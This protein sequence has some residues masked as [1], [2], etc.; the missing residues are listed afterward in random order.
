MRL[1]PLAVLAVPLAV[2][3]IG[4]DAVLDGWGLPL[5][6]AALVLAVLG[7]ARAGR[8]AVI[9]AAAAIATAGAGR[10][11]VRWEARH[12]P[13]RAERRIASRLAELQSRQSELV[14]RVRGLGRR[15]AALPDGR[16]A[17]S[18]DRAALIRLFRQLEELRDGV[19]DRPAVAVHS[20]PSLAVVAWSGRIGDP[21]VPAE[22]LT[23]GDDVFVLEGSV[24]TTLVSITSIKGPDGVLRGLV[25]TALPVSARRNIGNEYL[26]DFDLL[27]GGDPRVEA[28]Y[29][30]VREGPDAADLPPLDPALRAREA[31]LRGPDGDPLVLVRVVAPGAPEIREVL[32]TRYRRVLAAL[33]ALALLL[34]AAGAPRQPWQVALAVVGARAFFAFLGPPLP[35]PGSPL[36]SS[37]VYASPLLGLFS[38]SPLDLLMTAASALAVAL[39]ALTAARRRP[40]VLRPLALA[41]AMAAAVLTLVAAG[42]LVLDTVACSLLD[43]EVVTLVPPSQAHAVLQLALLAW[44]LAGLV[45]VTAAF[46]AAGVW[47]RALAALDARPAGARAGAF[48]ALVALAGGLLHPTLV[49]LGQRR[50]QRRLVAE[51]APLVLR[52]PEFR[53]FVLDETRKRI[54]SLRI[55]GEMPTGRARPGIEEMA[56]AVWTATDLAARGFSSAIEIQDAN[57]AVISRFALN[58]PSLSSRPLP[59]N[60]RW[61]VTPERSSLAST[62]RTVR[63]ARRLLTEEGQ[64]RG[65]V[66]VYVADDFWNLP[67]LR[68]SDPYSLLFR[69]APR[70]PVRQDPLVLIAYGRG[71]D[72]TFS[73]VERTPPLPTALAANLQPEGPGEWTV[74]SVDGQEHQ[75][76]L[77]AGQDAVY[78]LAHPRVSWGRRAADLVEAV[79]AFTLV[80]LCGLVVAIVV[81]TVLRKRELSLTSMAAAVQKRFALRLFVAFTVLAVA[82]VVVLEVVVRKFVADRLWEEANKHA[83][84]RVSVARKAVEDFVFFQRGEPAGAE[85]VTDAA[86]VWVASLIRNDLAVF[87]RGRLAASS[88]RELYASGLLA[89]RLSGAVYRTLVLEG[90]PSTLRTERIGGFSYLVASMP[91]RTAENSQS[92]VSLPLASRQREVEATVQD[93]DRTIRLA[94]LVFLGLAALFAQQVARRIS[95]PIRALTSATRRIAEGD[96]ATRVTTSSRDELM[97][98]VESFNQMAGDLDRQRSDL[99][100]S[101]R[102]AAWA[103]MARQVAH[104]VK[105]PLTPI[106]LSAEHLRR[107]WRD[108][109]IDFEGALESCTSTI[110]KQVRILRGIVTEFSAFARPPAAVLE[111]QDPARL[112]EGV[113]EPYRTALPPGVTLSVLSDG[114]VPTVMGD[115]RLLERALVNLLENALQA[116]GEAG[117]IEMGLRAAETG[118]RVELWVEDSG[119]GI[120]PELADRI[121]EPFFST[122]TGGSGLGLPLVRKIAEDHGGGVSLSRPHHGGTRATLW[123][124]TLSQG[125][126][127]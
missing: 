3:L 108:R 66:H 125:H 34:W 109:R 15:V 79:A 10:V 115:R 12:A 24:S 99:E 84:E 47:P 107:V 71:G 67:F 105:N 31:V 33:A 85:P 9:A 20:V 122:K 52:Q 77:F 56:F 49:L 98:L 16:T 5:M 7:G 76:Y 40:A 74:L 23:G 126:A 25:T 119:P 14:E 45:A 101:N 116:V 92:V 87:E 44:V 120:D 123:L 91:V 111:P 55:L 121:F 65:A 2:G 32:E 35:A 17:L 80:A 26:H 41:G 127:A 93:L 90:N 42:G 112:V 124:P 68:T 96:L 82:P 60:E 59:A 73:S 64:V 102:L 29:V 113:I 8:L 21:P 38:R 104:E 89:P 94:S 13:E 36:L 118:G 63:H 72:V 78:V 69:P 117:H 86:L 58:L 95:G 43:L 103:D 51:H 37:D 57:G 75:A 28:V 106:Q 22:T 100:R 27:T 54:D 62:A 1:R 83:L 53:D 88:K 70:A 19:A 39:C 97:T 50:L 11:H 110:L 4:F 6:G 48:L 114:P 30:D 18:Q 46:R 61:D 81:R